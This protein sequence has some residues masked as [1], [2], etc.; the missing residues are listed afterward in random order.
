[1]TTVAC[2]A[3][4][5]KITR[6]SKFQTES[7]KKQVIDS[8]HPISTIKCNSVTLQTAVNSLYLFVVYMVLD[9]IASKSEL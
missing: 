8:N 3:V 2:Q 9:F 7:D 4:S 1:M 6:H 5:V